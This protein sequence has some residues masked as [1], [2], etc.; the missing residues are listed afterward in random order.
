MNFLSGLLLFDLLPDF[1]SFLFILFPFC[2]FSVQFHLAATFFFSLYCSFVFV[3][4]NF[5]SVLFAQ[6]AVLFLMLNEQKQ[7]KLE[8]LCVACKRK[9][10][11]AFFSLI[12]VPQRKR[13]FW[14]DIM[15]QFKFC[16]SEK[17]TKTMHTVHYIKPY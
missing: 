7:E 4:L 5:H 6:I 1:V 15:N 12:F 2:F 8:I 14:Y 3:L 17:K 10:H 9:K 13:C 11:F 16:K